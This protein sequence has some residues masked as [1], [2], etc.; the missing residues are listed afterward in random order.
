MGWISLLG[1]SL[2]LALDAFAVATVTGIALEKT[3]HRHLF[4]LSFHFGLFQALML[5]GGWYL[6]IAVQRLISSFDHW[7]AFGLLCLVGG[8]IIRGALKPPD[9]EVVLDPTRGWD[10]VFLSVA[11]SVDALAVGISLAVMKT[12]IALAAVVVGIT[13]AAMTLTGMMLGRRIG[14]LMGRW[15]EFAGGLV[16]IVIGSRIL[17][18]HLSS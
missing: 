16:L 11:T 5:G 3:T 7:I 18:Q 15:C 6:G 12:P 8:N 10:L 17:W 9:D 4:R 13:A 2:A 14:L 1:I